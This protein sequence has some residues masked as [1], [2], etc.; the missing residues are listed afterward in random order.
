MLL[1]DLANKGPSPYIY[2]QLGQNYISLN[3]IEKAAHYYEL[4]LAMDVD[5]HSAY[6]Q[7]MM[8]T[9]GYCLLELEENEKSL[10]LIDKY[11]SYADRADFVYLIGM[12]YMMNSM[13]EKAIKEFEKATTIGAYS[14]KGVNS[15]RAFYNIGIISEKMGDREK[16]KSYYKKCGDYEPAVKRLAELG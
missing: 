11:A 13:W 7:S 1:H 3:D 15:Y 9:Y 6:V 2:F 8:E 14:R 5:P 10:T 12:I 16:A 4:G